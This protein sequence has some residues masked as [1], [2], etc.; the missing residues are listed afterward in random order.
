M[1]RRVGA[2]VVPVTVV[3]AAA[4]VVGATLWFFSGREVTA[5]QGTASLVR[6]AWQTIVLTALAGFTAMV[7][8][9]TANRLLLLRGTF[10]IRRLPGHV[11]NRARAYPRGTEDVDLGGLSVYEANAPL[12]QVMARLGHQVEAIVDDVESG[13]RRAEAAGAVRLLEELLGD[14]RRAVEALRTLES[15]PPDGD[16]PA[17][18]R[19]R[20]SGAEP[21][22]DRAEASLTLRHEVQDAL[23]ALQMRIAVE[24]RWRL[25]LM[26]STLSSV[27]ALVTLLFV[28]APPG[29][30]LLVLV[31]TFVMGGFFAGLFRDLVAIVE[32]ARVR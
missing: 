20:G 25:R 27:V 2:V 15:T 21:P 1:R 16:R 23:D 24:W 8:V 9:D 19:P 5:V 4:V 26:T 17:R 29:V 11:R 22:T 32:R 18:P 12:E 31:S 30:K 28:K 13:R 3:V 6:F 7:L 14:R 10:V